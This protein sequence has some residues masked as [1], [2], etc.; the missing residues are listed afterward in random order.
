MSEAADQLR[1]GIHNYFR[2]FGYNSCEMLFN[3][4]LRHGGVGPMLERLGLQDPGVSDDQYVCLLNYLRRN[5]V[6][7]FARRIASAPGR[8]TPARPNDEESR[9]RR[10]AAEALPYLSQPT[11]TDT[12]VYQRVRAKVPERFAAPAAKP[13]PPDAPPEPKIVA[14]P[15]ET[16]PVAPRPAARGLAEVK[17]D[18][19]T[20]AA[21][22][23]K[24][25]LGPDGKPLPP[26]TL[27]DGSW[28]G[29]TERRSGKER[30][31]GRERRKDVDVVFKN[32]R[33]GG[34]R[35][36]GKE[37]RKNWPPK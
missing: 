5:G 9:D 37:R 1:Q 35:R 26:G 22:A 15:V 21:P 29:V 25:N 30:R 19:K 3:E 33:Y 7:T 8:P 13:L 12:P 32:K 18:D 27:A 31:T 16:K 11:P 23:P 2:E 28:D 6:E 36:T 14:K 10:V 17:P 4:L 24:V 20:P 34:E